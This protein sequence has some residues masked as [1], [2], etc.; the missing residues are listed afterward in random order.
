MLRSLK[1]WSTRSCFL[2]QRCIQK[3]Q[4]ISTALRCGS[5][6]EKLSKNYLSIALSEILPHSQTI[7]NAEKFSAF[8]END[9]P[10]LTNF[11]QTHIFWKFDHISRTYNQINYRNIWFAKVT[12]IVIMMAGELFS[13]FF[14]RKTRTLMSLRS[15]IWSALQ[16][17]LQRYPS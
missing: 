2:I 7:K 16:N 13:I 14:S 3:S 17:K 9:S 12:T 6:S 8:V 4:N 15:M 5:F 10:C 11:L 1:F